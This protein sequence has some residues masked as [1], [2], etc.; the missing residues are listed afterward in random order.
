MKRLGLVLVLM[1]ACCGAS[2]SLHAQ[3]EK[4]LKAKQNFISSIGSAER[5]L[6]PDKITL[7]F[8]LSDEHIKGWID[9]AEAQDRIIAFMNANDIPAD[10]LTVETT[11]MTEAKA[12]DFRCEERKF[13]TYDIELSSVKQV[14]ALSNEL[15][16]MRATSV[17]ISETEIS[18]MDS[19]MDVLRAE[20]VVNAKIKAEK[21]MLPLGQKVGKLMV[22]VD[23]NAVNKRS[24][25]N[26]IKTLENAEIRIR[27]LASRNYDYDY[28]ELNEV[29]AVA[30]SN[31]SYYD[32]STPLFGEKFTPSVNIKFKPIKVKASVYAEFEIEDVSSKHEDYVYVQGVAKHKLMPDLIKLNINIDKEKLED[33]VTIEDVRDSIITKL[34]YLGIDPEEKFSFDDQGAHTEK[35]FFGNKKVEMSA[36]YIVEFTDAERMMVLIEMLERMNVEDYEIVDWDNCVSQQKEVIMELRTEAILNAKKRAEDMLKPT[37]DN[38]GDVISVYEMKLYTIEEYGQMYKRMNE[39]PIVAKTVAKLYKKGAEKESVKFSEIEIVLEIQVKFA[40]KRG[41]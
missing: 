12:M 5:E 6:I 40:I 10:K 32:S 21:Y 15:A 20:A 9:L 4:E 33:K 2:V 17:Y 11:M 22:L 16:A 7:T 3:A 28:G 36:S 13:V 14:Q 37:G 8:S 35:K 39:T 41:E 24:P 27:G 31:R 29:V 30:Y 1:L 23:E 34:Q 19:V 18:N 38:L 25:L 26:N